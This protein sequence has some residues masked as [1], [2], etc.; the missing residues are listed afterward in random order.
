[1][2][3]VG[4]DGPTFS[5]DLLAGANDPDVGA[6]LSVSGLDA[7]V[8]TT[9]GR[10]LVLGPDYTLSNS[11]LV[12]TAAGFG[13]FDSLA[14]LQTE[15]VVF[16]YGVSDG[17]LATA[18]ALTLNVAGADDAPTLI[19]QTA[20]QSAT[21]GTPFSLTLPSDTFQDPDTGDHLTLIAT[22]SNGMA[23]PSWLAFSA[24]T[25][26]FSGTPA[27]NNAGGFDVKVTATDPGGLAATDSFH[28]TVAGS[29]NHSPVITSDGAGTAASIIITDDTKHVETVHATDSDPNTTIK[30]SI[31]GG[32][33]QKLF[34][35]DPASGVLS[36]K[37]MPQ[38]G[39]SYNVTVSAS[40]GSL[41]DTQAINVQ[42]AK[43]VFEAGNAHVADNFVFKPGF[44]L[45]IVSNFD[46]TSANHDVLELD[47][48]LFRQSDP[49]ASSQ[50]IFDLI[51]HHS[52]QLG[53][54]VIIVADNFNLIDLRNTNLHALTPKDFLLT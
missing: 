3:N 26:T 18:D 54:D 52:F 29:A 1:V 15:Q 46:A 22:L 14:A 8:T 42:V 24:N 7:S 39:H 28:F 9:G 5:Q 19:H 27:P 16:H 36:F 48:A 23:L 21:A 6:T 47:H 12:L 37:N 25:G 40:D 38:D 50:A 2:R 41:Q 34:N 17:I 51:E 20:S 35:I 33:D 32:Q 13:K 45:E 10:Q 11:T 44:G 30:Y 53:S 49:H 31:V 43:G 4:E